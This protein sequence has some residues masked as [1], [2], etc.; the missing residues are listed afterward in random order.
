MLYRNRADEGTVTATAQLSAL[1]AGFL[2]QTH[3]AKVWRTATGT[4]TATLRVDLG[5]AVACSCLA[6]AGLNLSATG[7]VRVT[8]SNVSATGTEL[9][10]STALTGCDPEYRLYVRAFAS[11][12]ARYW[13][14]VISDPSLSYLEAGRIILGELWVPTV[15]YQFGLTD[16]IRRTASVTVSD[17]GQSWSDIKHDRRV[18][19]PTFPAINKTDK[20]A[21][22]AEIRR[23]GAR[24][25]DVLFVPNTE[26]TNLSRDSLWAEL[27]TDIQ[28]RRDR[29]DIFNMPLTLAERL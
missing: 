28:F 11:V 10:D 25:R 6:L 4:T 20:E 5:A 23:Y 15:G 14:V 2:Q 29:F 22:F 1:P 13:Q 19:T 21:R 18:M 8:A 7:T 12:E 24:T 16:N 17:G 26:S 3:L 27:E 9:Y